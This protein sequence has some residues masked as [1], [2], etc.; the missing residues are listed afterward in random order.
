MLPAGEA[1]EAAID[2]LAPLLSPGD[3]LVD[4]AN[5]FYQEAMRRAGELARRA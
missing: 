3:L 4:G 2:E 1:T 5:G